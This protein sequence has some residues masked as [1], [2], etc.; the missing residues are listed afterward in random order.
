MTTKL[1][2][3][4][5]AAVTTPPQ[6]VDHD[7]AVSLQIILAEYGR[8]QHDFQFSLDTMNHAFNQYL[9]GMAFLIAGI[10]GAALV[11]KEETRLLMSLVICG[12]A[13]AIALVTNFTVR[14]MHHALRAQETTKASLDELQAYLRNANCEVGRYLYPSKLETGLNPLT[15]IQG[16]AL[17]TVGGFFAGVSVYSL[18]LAFGAA[19]W[20]WAVPVST[21]VGIG[22]VVLTLWLF[23][24]RDK[25]N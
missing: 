9:N 24:K 18:F 15:D 14:R 16:V 23:Y 7:I 20:L 12:I 1:E 25:K 2:K 17:L 11:W 5:A 6:D 10:S 8:K 4:S 19:D 3:P 21:V 22:V 13:F